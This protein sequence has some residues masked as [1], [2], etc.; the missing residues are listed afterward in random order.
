MLREKGY[1]TLEVG[2]STESEVLE[3]MIEEQ[4]PHLVVLLADSGTDAATLTVR[5]GG[6]TRVAVAC[7]ATLWVGGGAMWPLVD[8]AGHFHTLGELAAASGRMLG[9]EAGTAQ[10]AGRVLEWVRSDE[11]REAVAEGEG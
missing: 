3:Q 10:I 5:I 2:C 9:G 4:Q 11:V 6:V 1:S 7:G 8:G